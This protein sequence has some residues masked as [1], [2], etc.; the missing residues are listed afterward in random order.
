MTKTH[1]YT[2][3]LLILATGA[4]LVSML[5]T[6]DSPPHTP[7]QT[8]VTSFY[9]LAYFTER[10]AEGTDIAI[11]N[12]A[13]ARDPH[14]Y[15]PSRADIERMLAANL[16]IMQGAQLESWAEDMETRLESEGVPMLVVAEHLTLHE[17]ADDDHGHED[18]EDVY[19]HADDDEHDEGTSHEE[20]GHEGEDEH[21]NEEYQDEDGHA[22]GS[23][24]PHTWL[25]PVLAQDMVAEIR[26]ALVAEFPD[27][28]ETIEA[29][30]QT[31]T[32]DLTAVD[33]AYTERLATCTVEE[34]IISHDAAGYLARR[35]NLTFHAIAGLST[36]DEPSAMLLAELAEEAAGKRAILAEEGTVTA[37][38]ET[39]SRE[40]GLEMVPLNPLGRGPL[41]DDKDYFDVMY[42]NLDSLAY[43]FG[44]DT[45]Q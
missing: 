40:T 34:A 36:E 37:Y 31:L 7:D 26:D 44:C 12:L 5:R 13:G 35:Y 10:I 43:A 28:A 20:E 23:Y 39:L 14:D 15:S 29:N 6:D 27:D 41:T 19:M 24:D 11:T 2:L 25:D 17:M 21:A 22:H 4:G 42:A 9:P 1:I 45:T 33:A 8:V 3:A 16:V 18:E 32:S 30:A 38:A